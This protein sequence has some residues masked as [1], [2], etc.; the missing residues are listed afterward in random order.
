MI[1]ALALLLSA[2]APASGD[3]IPLSQL[4]AEYQNII[5]LE[6]TQHDGESFTGLD[7]DSLAAEH[8]L[9]EAVN[10]NRHYLLYLAQH[11][12]RPSFS[13]FATSERP[14]AEVREDYYAVLEGDSTF[15]AA[16]QPLFGRYLNERGVVVDGYDHSRPR[17]AVRMEDVINVAVRFFYPDTILQDGSIE[18]H[19]CASINGVQDFQGTRDLALE[20]FAYSAIFRDIF[21]PKHDVRREYN[22]VKAL[23][24]QVGL[25]S[26]PEVRLTRA[27][28]MMWGHMAQSQ[29]LRAALLEE[30]QA[31][32]EYLPFVI[33]DA[34]APAHTR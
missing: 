2:A 31:K 16:V 10:S 32:R 23:M 28:G 20:A 4:R 5:R 18:G 11:A 1:T 22:R 19:I 17:S 12:T 8:P 6:Q 13:E 9:S 27:Q 26:D 7:V 21:Q 33:T 29:Q 24:N 34:P 3:T 30:Y 15:N 25:S 14:F